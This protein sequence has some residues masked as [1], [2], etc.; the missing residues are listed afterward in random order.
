M[1]RRI[2][3]EAARQILNTAFE[4]AAEAFRT[5]QPPALP[6]PAAQQAFDCIF[7]SATQAY[8][9]ALLGCIVAYIF[10]DEIDIRYP[11]TRL[12]DNSF[13]G[14][15]LDER[16]INPFLQ[17][18]EI[19]CSK[20][21]YLSSLRRAVTFELP[22]PEGQRDQEAFTQTVRLVDMIRNGDRDNA[23]HFL[24]YIL[25]KFLMLREASNIEI[26]RI[27]RLS[28]DQY[29]DLLSRLLETPSGGRIPV[30]IVVAIFQAIE[31]TFDLNWEIEWQ[32]INA[33]DSPSHAKGDI[34]IR[35]D[36]EIVL[37]VEVTERLIDETRVRSTFRTKISP[38]SVD[39]Y[40]FFFTDAPPNGNAVLAAKQYFAQGH[41]IGFLSV[42]D[43][44]VN[45]LGTIGPEGRS[46]FM[47]IITGLLSRND[48]PRE[49]K[50]AW[51]HHLQKVIAE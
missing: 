5:E 18:Y 39:D 19:P 33:P 28:I 27:Q 46:H 20:G 25:Y 24:R 29:R 50:V 36:N 30:L 45:I 38:S 47:N 17:E 7:A 22:V 31:R 40:L 49:I 44:S 51:N 35:Q 23:W 10:D 15:S 11:H 1:A 26:V 12:G 8:R 6:D 3:Y 2:D 13:S 37:A 21:P 42:K 14:R 32:E 16:V 43:W 9:E 4:Q 41:H 34:T 48:I